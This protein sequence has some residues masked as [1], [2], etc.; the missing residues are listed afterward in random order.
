MFVWRALSTGYTRD[1]CY[2]CYSSPS[3]ANTSSMNASIGCLFWSERDMQRVPHVNE[4]SPVGV[5]RCSTAE[6]VV[7]D[8]AAE[9]SSHS[10]DRNGQQQSNCR[11]LVA[12]EYNAVFQIQ[13]TDGIPMLCMKQGCRRLLAAV[14]AQ[15][16]IT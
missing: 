3:N 12:I 14:V 15:S 13:Y 10:H 16:A 7:R 1:N 5:C 11:M 9:L 2:H 6:T 8:L 4:P